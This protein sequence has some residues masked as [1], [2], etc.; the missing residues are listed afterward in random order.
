[1]GSQVLTCFSHL[2]SLLSHLD[3][4]A[5]RGLNRWRNIP[6]FLRVGAIARADRRIVVIF[7]RS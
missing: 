2:L 1:M 7:N 6:V 3:E 5:G 4:F